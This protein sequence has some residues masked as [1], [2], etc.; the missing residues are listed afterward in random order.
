[1][2][3][4]LDKAL[5]VNFGIQFEMTLKIL[6]QQ[7]RDATEMEAGRL[8]KELEKAQ[9][10]LAKHQEAAE[11]TRIEF[12]RMSAELSR[13]MDKLE[14]SEGEKDGLKQAV[15]MFEQNQ[16]QQSHNEKQF[17]SIQAEIHQLS[18]ER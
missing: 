5:Q 3:D 17:S 1:M 4:G 11:S 2:R 15:K 7:Q 13:V 12:E 9:I 14:K 10:H 6:S 16:N 18:V 8:A